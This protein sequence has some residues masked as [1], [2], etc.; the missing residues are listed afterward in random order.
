MSRD[1]FCASFIRAIFNVQNFEIGV[2]LK[3]LS[4][5]GV[6]NCYIGLL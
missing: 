4:D 1:G 3:W 6:V 2:V 5:F